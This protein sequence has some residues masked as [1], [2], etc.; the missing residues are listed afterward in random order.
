MRRPSVNWRCNSIWQAYKNYWWPDPSTDFNQNQRLLDELKKKV[1]D[2]VNECD[3]RG[4]I[5]A[6][7]DILDWGRVTRGNVERL[8][9]LDREALSTFE[10]AS[11]QLDPLSADTNRLDEVT[12]INAGWTKLYSLMLD[13]FPIYDSRVSGT[14][15][16]LVLTYCIERDLNRV[17]RLLRFGIAPARGRNRNPSLCSWRFPQLCSNSRRWAECNLWAAWILGEVCNEGSFVSVPRRHRLRAIEAAL[18][19]IGYELPQ[20]MKRTSE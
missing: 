14:L 11:R 4:F 15:G 10:R 13:R 20:K 12:Y 6:A 5:K 16:Y 2:M 9:I 3:G 19:M 8:R 17:P 18:F 1:L 7:S